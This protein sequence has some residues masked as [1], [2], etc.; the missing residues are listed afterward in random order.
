MGAVGRPNPRRSVLHM[1]RPSQHAPRRR[2]RHDPL[3]P[4]SPGGVRRHVRHHPLRVAPLVGA[5][6]RPHRRRRQLRRRANAAA[7]LLQLEILDGG[8]ADVD[9]RH[10]RGLHA[11]RRVYPFPAV[12]KHAFSGVQE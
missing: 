6:L 3:L 11:P 5:H 2:R 1:A 8:G 12:G 9:G 10:G 7:V 4:R